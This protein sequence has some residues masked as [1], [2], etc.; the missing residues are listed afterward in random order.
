M[1]GTRD[2][3]VKVSNHRAVRFGSDGLET[4]KWEP[5]K[6]VPSKRDTLM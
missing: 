3:L 5:K 4:E 6:G 2:T 1:V